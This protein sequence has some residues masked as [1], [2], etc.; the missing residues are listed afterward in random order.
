[1]V[2][3]AIFRYLFD[4]LYVERTFFHSDPSLAERFTEHCAFIA[5]CSPRLLGI[6]EHLLA[7][8]QFDQ[9]LTSLVRST[10]TFRDI[11]TNLSS[12]RF[13]NSPADVL[14]LLQIIFQRLD[15]VVRL[16]TLERKL[17]RFLPMV[18]HTRRGKRV[19]FMSFDD[20]LSLF[21]ALLAV[22]PPC[23]ALEICAAF[24]HLPWL[25]A[26]VTAGP[27]MAT[28]STAVEYICEFSADQLVRPEE[29]DEVDDPL[30]I[31][32]PPPDFSRCAEN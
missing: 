12:L 9:G 20:C 13:V 17:G 23:N 28:F 25:S 31:T 4:K 5:S 6:G 22:D 16:N 21:F 32:R 2:K 29:G 1:V 3:H 11:A 24:D 19:S 15:E 18:D 27:T 14:Y 26:A 8:A 7:P 10:G 30:G